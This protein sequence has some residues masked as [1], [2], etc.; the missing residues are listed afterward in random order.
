MILSEL[1]QCIEQQGYVTRKELA[2]RFALSE[3][4]VDAMLEVWIKKGV[5]S[6]LIDTNAAN[7]V[8]RVRYC[9]NRVNGLSMTVTM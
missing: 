9:P 1:K 8:T 3:D 7:Y 5:I 4:G 6:R 2:Q